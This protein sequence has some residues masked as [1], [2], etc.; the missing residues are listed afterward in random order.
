MQDW[1]LMMHVW[2]A[3]LHVFRFTKF[4]LCKLN[5]CNFRVFIAFS[6]MRFLF[7]PTTFLMCV[8][9]PVLFD[10]LLV[11]TFVPALRFHN[12]ISIIN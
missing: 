6:G 12:N 10:R 2:N 9:I 4:Q 5:I 1:A 3:I 8:I 11:V 7:V